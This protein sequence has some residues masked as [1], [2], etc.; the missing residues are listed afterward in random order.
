[1][2]STPM[3]FSC[4]QCR[5]V[6]KAAVGLVGAVM[7][8]PRC[9]QQFKVA[10][11]DATAGGR[12]GDPAPSDAEWFYLEGGQPV[13]PVPTGELRQRARRGHLRQTDLVWRDG[14]SEWFQARRVKGLF[15]GLR[16]PPPLPDAAHAQAPPWRGG[17]SP[18][19]S[20]A[21]PDGE[22]PLPREALRY[23]EA[24]LAFL[25]EHENEGPACQFKARA[26]RAADIPHFA[27]TFPLGDI[28]AYRGW[29]VFLTAV[30]QPP[31]LG[32][33][34]R[35]VVVQLTAGHSPE[36]LG[37]LVKDFARRAGSSLQSD[38]MVSAAFNSPNSFFVPLGEVVEVTY[39]RGFPVLHTARIRVKCRQDSFVICQDEN[40]ELGGT[41]A[42]IS[43]KWHPDFVEMLSK[44]AREN[45]GEGPGGFGLL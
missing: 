25:A 18:R 31:G 23:R 41:W 6:L 17:L 29:L 35:N 8:C 3:R 27:L 5:A 22:K 9:G 14:F 2:S 44:A 1:M 10:A 4:P 33:A 20:P 43:G 19:E 26:A 38:E 40:A 21:D 32:L 12:P 15:G 7:A 30:E 36:S 11:R 24:F 42:L 37:A 28:L 39:K 13:G 34:V 16:L 45:A